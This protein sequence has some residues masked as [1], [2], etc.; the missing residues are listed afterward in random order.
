MVLAE[1]V[2]DAV[3]NV[4][5]NKVFNADL[6]DELKHYEYGQLTETE[7]FSAFK[8]LFE[9]Y[10]KNGDREKFYG[11]YYAQVPLKSTSFFRG[12]SRHAAT[13]LAIK[14]ADSMLAHCKRMKSS[15]DNS[16]L[17]SKSEKE[18]AGL[19]YLGGYAWHNLHKKCARKFSNE[20]QQAMAIL[21]A[22]KLKYGSD[23]QKLVSSL[24]RGGLW[25]MTESAQNIFFRT[26]HYFRQSTLR[27]AHSLQRVDI[28]GIAQKSV[29]DSDVVSNYQ[30][31]VSDAV[32]VPTKNVSK[33]VLD[34][35]V[36]LYIRVR[37]FSLAKDTIQH[38]KINAKQ[39]KGK[40][41]RKEIQRSCD[42]Q[43]QERRN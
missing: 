38:F 29:S 15:P 41:L 28:A 43:T 2:N 19:Q 32:L 36:N 30:T 8:I 31:M 25:P 20:S 42:E 21:K 27:G 39:A 33:D 13:L 34:S 16:V 9:G 11:K 14:V 37:S 1:I 26:E 22:G 12:L 5:E 17:P 35:I 10:L 3:K 40:A 4:K 7:K 23:S 18:T 24:D 6:R